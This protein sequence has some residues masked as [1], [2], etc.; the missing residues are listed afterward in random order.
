MTHID[1]IQVTKRDGRLEPIDLDKIHKVIA[2]AADGL[3]NVSVS[4]VELKSHIQFYEGIK[5]RDIHE[6]IIKSAADLISETTP[7]YQYLAARLAIFHLRKIAYNRF[8]PPHLYDHV[9][10]LT[11]AGKYDEH[12][13]ADYSRAEFDELE[14]YLDHWRDMNLAYA[15]VEQMAGK[16]LVQDRVT[17]TVYESPQFLYMLV[18]MCL[19]AGYDKSDRLYY[20]KRFYDATSEFKISLPT[21]IMSGVRTPSR[22]F[23][24]CVLIECGD[25]LDSINATTSAIVR[26]VSQRAGIG[27]N[28][29]RIRALG[30]PIRGGEAQHTG[31]IPFYKLFQT[32]VKCCSQGGVRGGAATLFYPLWHLEVESLLVLKN[33]RGVEDNRVRH[34]DYGV[35]LNKTMYTRLIKGQDISLFS[36]G[37]TPGLYDAFF[38]DQDKFEEL[39]TKYEN[40]PNVRSRQIPA[41]DLFSLMMQERASTGRIYIQNVDHCN[42]HSP[43]DATVAPIRQSNLCMEIALPTKPMDNINDESGE[44][45]LCTLSAVNLGKVENVSDIE[46]PAELIVRALDALLDYQDYPV[47]AAQ[48]GSMRRRTLGVGVINYAYY[49]AKNGARYSDDSALGLTHQTFEALQYYLLKASN[50]LAKEQGACPAFNETT[51]SQ[52]ILPIDTY[53]AD[54]DKI[55]QEPLH[56]DWETLRGEITEHGLRNSTLTALMPSETSSQIA[57]ATNG[58]EPPRGLV[59]IKASKDG[60][61]KQVVPEIDKLKDQYE[62]LWQMPNNDGYLKLVAIMQKFV[63]QSISANTN[64][65]PVRY[66]GGRVPMKILLKDL[67]NA[68]K[69]GVKTL[70][71]HNTRDGANDAQ[72]DMEDDCAGG[73]CKI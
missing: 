67:L 59:S 15:A 19:F 36:P 72:A 25:S 35:Q 41:A 54:L 40:D 39:Y 64:Y 14:E 9:K 69:M 32:A 3:D 13:L 8:T 62:L 61:L 30:S 49:L 23:S 68:Y 65:D 5:T 31:C 63:D 27:I 10:T 18:G 33:N 53:K 66:A 60:I 52:G 7:D 42:T 24:S 2:W 4:Q 58:I 16:Y 37:D 73:A 12:I 28:A 1:N 6:T 17:K 20:V 70:Y 29:G 26:Y 56:L 57:N 11:D 45:A 50:K 46:E 55:C 47:K 38:E 51:Y 71:Y 21:P 22:Q 43:F 44:I 34:M 48:N